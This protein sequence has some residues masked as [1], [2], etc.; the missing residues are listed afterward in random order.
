VSGLTARLLRSSGTRSAAR[1]Q[2]AQVAQQLAWHQG[3]CA[4]A[5]QKGVVDH[6]L[7]VLA[8]SSSKEAVRA[9]AVRTLGSFWGEAL[10][11]QDSGGLADEGVQLGAMAAGKSAGVLLQ[12][13]LAA[14]AGQ[15]WVA[16]AVLALDVVVRA[17]VED[18]RLRDAAVADVAQLG[19]LLQLPVGQR[20]SRTAEVQQLADSIL[21][22]AGGA[23]VTEA[24]AGPAAARADAAVAPAA[25]AAPAAAVREGAAPKQHA[26]AAAADSAGCSAVAQAGA[27]SAAR[28]ASGRASSGGGGGG[29]SEEARCGQCGAKAGEG[30]KLQCCAACKQEWYCG[31]MCQRMHWPAHKAACKAARGK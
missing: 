17:G 20:R 15:A 21:R 30:C 6:L 28:R 25:G 3:L 7:A 31:A 13:M 23:A 26:G 22:S 8:S 2:A 14:K 4:Q 11:R 12:A 10:L 29:S 5:L 27:G 16:T 9:A 19:A 18:T 1:E 24:A